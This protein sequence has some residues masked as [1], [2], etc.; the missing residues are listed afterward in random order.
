MTS[1]GS[2][3]VLSPARLAL[4]RAIVH[5]GP[6]HDETTVG[7][8]EGWPGMDGLDRVGL[9]GDRVGG[10]SG[11][12]A[13]PEPDGDQVLSRLQRYRRRAAAQRGEPRAGRPVGRGR[14]YLSAR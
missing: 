1:L 6:A 5:G 10:L 3:E 14:R 13:G 11:V 9:A 4:T 12:G 7:A 8:G 2:R